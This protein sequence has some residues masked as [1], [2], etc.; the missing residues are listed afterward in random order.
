MREAFDEIAVDLRQQYSIGYVPTNFQVD[1]KLRRIK[2][3][4]SQAQSGKASLRHRTGYIANRKSQAEDV[5][6]DN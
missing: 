4:L 2:I 3:K 5:R 6:A 1:G